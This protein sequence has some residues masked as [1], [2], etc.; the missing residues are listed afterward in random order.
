VVLV[1]EPDPL[2]GAALWR[3]LRRAYEVVWV[4][5]AGEALTW[6]A[7]GEV[8]VV[9]AAS[10]LGEGKTGEDLLGQ[11][12]ARWPDVWRVLCSGTPGV[13]PRSKHAQGLVRM[14]ADLE[15][16]RA[17]IEGETRPC[18]CRE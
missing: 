8:A 13:V 17:A 5:S 11:V 12:A 10:N 15:D 1:V 6:L 3:G 14:P 18:A 9:V 2:V 7:S 4:P 16:Y